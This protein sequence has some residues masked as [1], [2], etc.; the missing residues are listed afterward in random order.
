MVQGS[1]FGGPGSGGPGCSPLLE[2]HIQVAGNL[3]HGA[4]TRHGLEWWAGSELDG[5]IGLNAGLACNTKNEQNHQAR[6]LSDGMTKLYTLQPRTSSSD[7]CQAF[8]RDWLRNLD[9][10]AAFN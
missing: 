2:A 8:S 10:N 5:D 4:P 7:S 6:L 9:W 3:P 1:V